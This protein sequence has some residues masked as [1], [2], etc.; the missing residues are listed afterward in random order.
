M[1]GGWATQKFIWSESGDSAAH[2]VCP[3][4]ASED[5]LSLYCAC[6]KAQWQPMLTTLS[7]LFLF[8]FFFQ[9]VTGLTS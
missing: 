3:R 8:F 4:P 5:G 6:T 9:F 2:N 7:T 1:E